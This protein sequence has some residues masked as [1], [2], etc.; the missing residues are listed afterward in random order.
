[1]RQWNRSLPPFGKL[2]EIM[3]LKLYALTKKRATIIVITLCTPVLHIGLSDACKN[4][5]RI[6]SKALA[7]TDVFRLNINEDQKS[8]HAYLH[9]DPTHT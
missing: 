3:F 2:P 4:R 1:M 6:Y 9:K 5:A 7:S 8:F